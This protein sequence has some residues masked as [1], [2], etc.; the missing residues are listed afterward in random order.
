[1]IRDF[2][3]W[4]R[5]RGVYLNVPDY[6][7]L[8]GSTKSAM[9]YRETNWSLPRARQIIHARQNIFDGTSNT[10]LA[11]EILRGD[12]DGGAYTPGEPVINVPYGAFPSV[13]QTSIE[14]WA[15]QCEA[16]KAG[17]LNS[18]G[19]HWHGGQHD[20]ER[21]QYGRPAKL[22]IAHV[23]RRQSA[24]DGI[25]PGWDVPRSQPASLSHA[26]HESLRPASR[27]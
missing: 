5:A 10:I 19:W 12:G 18:N 24:W 22:Q 9:G 16:G 21:L 27:R 8:A 15:L 3:R 13:A 14:P 2:Y 1:M 25:G 11:S 7:Y 20:A 6:Y 4:C 23:H 17:H 26:T